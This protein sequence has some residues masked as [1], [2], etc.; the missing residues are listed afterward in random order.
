MRKIEKAKVQQNG[1]EIHIHCGEQLGSTY[2]REDGRL[3]F[4]KDTKA[5]KNIISMKKR[6]NAKCECGSGKKQK[7]CCGRETKYFSKPVMMSK[8]TALNMI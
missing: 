2:K 5:T 3:H 4:I 1:D 7:H 8:K 6:P